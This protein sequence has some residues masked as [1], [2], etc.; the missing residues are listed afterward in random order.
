MPLFEM[1]LQSTFAGQQCVNVYNYVGTGIPA[2][3][4][5]SFA[6]MTQFGCIFDP[7]LAGGSYPITGNFS[8]IR[9]IQNPTVVYDFCTVKNVY[10]LVDFYETP[11]LQPAI[12][13]DTAG[14]SSPP[15]VSYGYRTGRARGDIGRG[16]KR[17]V[18]ATE[19][20]VGNQG[21]ITPGFVSGQMST[22]ALALSRNLVYDDNGNN[23][24]FSPCVVK[25]QRYV[26]NP[27]RPERYAYR[28]FPTEAEQM[29]N[30]ATGITYDPYPTVRSQVS[31][32]VGRG[33]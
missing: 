22:V 33:R 12:G 29:T 28:Y 19:T 18:G 17:F 21:I 7:E 5:M 20:R 31:R 25:K 2:S 11:F 14:E 26:P 24:T 1:T 10:D 9:S 32:Q 13:T 4:S 23:L 15:F 16:Y 27:D 8:I 3:V 30:V 6:L